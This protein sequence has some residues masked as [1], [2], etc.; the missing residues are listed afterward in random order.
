VQVLRGTGVIAE[1][2]TSKEG[3]FN[4]RLA[5]G[6]YLVRATNPGAYTSINQQAVALVPAGTT[7]VLLTVD[8]GIR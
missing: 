3:V 1:Q 5:A 7:R 4:F 2:Q 8:T 6:T